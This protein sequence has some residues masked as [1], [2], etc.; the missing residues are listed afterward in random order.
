M[1]LLYRFCP[2]N[3]FGFKE[4]VF[5][6][7]ERTFLNESRTSKIKSKWGGGKSL[8]ILGDLK[9]FWLSTFCWSNLKFRSPEARAVTSFADEI[10]NVGI[11]SRR[12]SKMSK[13]SEDQKAIWSYRVLT[14][15]A[16]YQIISRPKSKMSKSSEDQTQN[17]PLPRKH[18]YT[19]HFQ[20]QQSTWNVSLWSSMSML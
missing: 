20:S 15:N 4:L 5:F 10:Q 2:W 7:K 1:I 16:K 17:E 19:E 11:V 12:K 18:I 9:K 8:W 3:G 14:K 6:F 13:S